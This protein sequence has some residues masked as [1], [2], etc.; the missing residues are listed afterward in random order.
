MIERLEAILRKAA[1]ST[2]LE[3]QKNTAQKE[4][5]K[6]ASAYKALD[7][8]MKVGT[9][10]QVG[11]D[12]D[13]W[14]LLRFGTQ[15]Q[16]ESRGFLSKHEGEKWKFNSGKVDKHDRP[17]EKLAKNEVKADRWKRV[18]NAINDAQAAPY[19]SEKHY[20][21]VL[22]DVYRAEANAPGGIGQQKYE[23]WRDAEIRRGIKEG[24]IE[25]RPN[26]KVRLAEPM[27][28]RDRPAEK[29][30]TGKVKKKREHGR[31]M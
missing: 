22:H 9:D 18:K 23:E 13:L 7:Q 1:Q 5:Q 4:R 6:D 25:V 14:G 31:S 20:D 17:A 15:R 27:K 24:F 29:L 3:A 10:R 16:A 19:Y 28:I 30:L 11:A 26:G 2:R 8:A 21:E 12:A